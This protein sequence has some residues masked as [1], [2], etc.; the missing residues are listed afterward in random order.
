[1]NKYIPVV[2][3]T[4]GCEDDLDEGLIGDVGS[5]VDELQ[6]VQRA[7]VVSEQQDAVAQPV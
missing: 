5:G 2:V 6:Y 1:M 3:L 7:V 4:V